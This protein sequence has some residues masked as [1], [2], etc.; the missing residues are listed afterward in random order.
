M[1]DI[2]TENKDLIKLE[3]DL[4]S[5]EDY[6]FALTQQL[7]VNFDE[8]HFYVRFY[9]L[10]PPVVM[11][12]DKLDKVR[13]RLVSGIA[14]PIEHFPNFIEA[15][16]RNLERYQELKSEKESKSED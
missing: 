2:V 8:T 1:G 5:D 9:Q 15:L 4:E 7:V 11:D 6:H 13:A 12:L 16:S 3:I 14:V 10:V